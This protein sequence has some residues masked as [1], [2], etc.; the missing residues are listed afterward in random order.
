MLEELGLA[1][2]LHW[3]T[4]GT[5]FYTHDKLYSLSNSIEFL[6]F[7]PLNL[8]DKVRLAFTILYASRVKDGRR[9][10]SIPITTWLERLSGRRTMERIWIPL[11][12]SKLGENYKLAS[13]SFIW[14]YLTR[15]YRARQSGMKREMFG[16]VEGGYDTILKRFRQLLEERDVEILCGRPANSVIDNGDAVAVHLA[17]GESRTFDKVVLT[18]PSGRAAALCPQFTDAERQRLESVVYQGV[19]CASLLLRQPLARYYVTNITDSWVPFTAV[20]EATTLVDR[21][22]FGG[23]SLVYLPR[24]LAQND[25]FWR[26]SDAEIEAEFI[27]ALEVM[28]PHFRR[29]DVLAFHVSRARD[30]QAVTT[31]HYSDRV[32]PLTRTSLESV[33]VVNSAQIVNATLNVNETIGL[34]NAKA[35]ELAPFLSAPAGRLLTS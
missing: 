8:V 33:F 12:K 9:L 24:Y 14:A 18:V 25:P 22:H 3:G 17:T 29:S 28:Y 35:A 26:K 31:L 23:N 32:L 4:T 20:V 1:H 13:A 10:E 6:T 19:V 30:V 16:Y 27:K 21:A 34:A 11:L 5:G 15:L 7:P 2:L